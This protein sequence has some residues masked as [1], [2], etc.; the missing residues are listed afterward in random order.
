MNTLAILIFLVIF[1]YMVQ[2]VINLLIKERM[3]EGFIANAKGEP[4]YIFDED[5]SPAN[6]P[7]LKSRDSHFFL[8]RAISPGKKAVVD[9]KENNPWHTNYY[10]VDDEAIK[11]EQPDPEVV[12]HRLSKLSYPKLKKKD[13]LTCIPQNA[14]IRALVG[15]YQ[16]YMYDQPKI[17]DYYDTP[18]YRDW[19]YPQQPID[20]RFLANEEKYCA[21]FPNAYP[22]F[23]YYMKW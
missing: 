15:K 8:V 5:Y 10:Y 9:L 7:A 21:Q 6:N 4:R 18:L 20:L 17:L 11:M 12:K 1:G 16:P 19:R 22:C 2:Y 13:Q 3:T 14:P 23:R